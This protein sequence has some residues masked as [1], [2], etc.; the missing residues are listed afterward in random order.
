MLL[1][2]ELLHMITK[3]WF[4]EEEFYHYDILADHLIDEHGY[5]F[6]EAWYNKLKYGSRETEDRLV[7]LYQSLRTTDL[8]RTKAE[9]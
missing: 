2:G 7:A 6:D 5:V 1:H 3:C 4:D 9:V 8:N